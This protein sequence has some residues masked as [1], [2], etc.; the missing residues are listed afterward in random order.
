MA[1]FK[2]ALKR[3]PLQV[4]ALC[5]RVAHRLF[6]RACDTRGARRALVI[7]LGGIGDALRVFPVIRD[8]EAGFPGLEVTTL[9]SAPQSLFDMLPGCAGRRRHIH[10]P[11]AV[12]MLGKVRIVLGLRRLGLDL[13]V[14]A[15][16]GDG[17]IE[18][19][20]AALAAGARVRVGF[21]ADGAGGFHTLQVPF[22]DRRSILVQNLDLVRAL[23][24]RT[25]EPRIELALGDDARA[26]AEHLL[27]EFQAARPRLVA[28]HPWASSHP[29]F[30]EWPEE[31]Y[32]RLLARLVAAG[33]GVVLLGGPDEAVRSRE[34]ARRV[35]AAGLLDLA[36]RTGFA[37]AAAVIERCGRFV[38]NDSSLLHLAGA[39]GARSVVV[40]GATPPEQVLAPSQSCIAL[41]AGLACQP[42]YRHQPLFRYRC[43]HR[44]RCLRSVSVADVEEALNRA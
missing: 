31:R 42:C 39:V 28:V 30:R 36:G 11:P 35:D 43:E 10:L 15:T 12:S 8:L 41:A 29:E 5:G 32:A 33:D 27:H 16:R 22:D 17:M 21:F 37:E 38:G 44:F 18:C 6:E 14:D 40:F 1:L 19:D 23:G 34:L 3:P 4:A 13:V 26:R 2:Q 24:I 20:L 9:T 25:G 7:Q